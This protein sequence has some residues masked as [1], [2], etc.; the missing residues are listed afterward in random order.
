MTAIDRRKCGNNKALASARL[1]EMQRCSSQSVQ[2]TQL[3]LVREDCSLHE[4]W[5]LRERTPN[6]MQVRRRSPVKF[7]QS[8]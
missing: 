3:S 7:G 4:E 8:F 1:P 5:S 2:F 6:I